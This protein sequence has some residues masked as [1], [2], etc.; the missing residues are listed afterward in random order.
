MPEP[1]LSEEATHKRKVIELNLLKAKPVSYD[2]WWNSDIRKCA[3]KQI[4]EAHN[5]FIK[6]EL[7]NFTIFVCVCML[8]SLIPT[9]AAL[10]ALINF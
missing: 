5:G 9:F 2:L 10:Y 6:D 8:H 4:H 7:I 3:S 1:V